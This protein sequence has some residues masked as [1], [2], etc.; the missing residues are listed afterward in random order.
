MEVDSH[1]N[2]FFFFQI[3]LNGSYTYV[4][5]MQNKNRVTKELC[6]LKYFDC[7]FCDHHTQLSQKQLML[8]TL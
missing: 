4:S 8:Y 5:R 6:M 1:L 7:H 2:I 3:A